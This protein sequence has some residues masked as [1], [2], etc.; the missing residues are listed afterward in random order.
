MRLTYDFCSSSMFTISS[1][2]L[3]FASFTLAF[4]NVLQHTRVVLVLRLLHLLL[5]LDCSSFRFCI[6]SS[7]HMSAQM[8]PLKWGILLPFYLKQYSLYEIICQ[9]ACI[10]IYPLYFIRSVKELVFCFVPHHIPSIKNSGL[11]TVDI[12]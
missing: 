5:C 4:F 9:L 11:Y 10:Y 2:I 7:S 12:W 1:T 8:S 6:A 3:L